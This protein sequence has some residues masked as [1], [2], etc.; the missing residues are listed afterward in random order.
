[1]YSEYTTNVAEAFKVIDDLYKKS[2]D[3]KAVV[4]EVR[5]MPESRNLNINFHMSS[6][7]QRLTK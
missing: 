3:F 2:R 6:L 4:D 1:M 5:G 7:H